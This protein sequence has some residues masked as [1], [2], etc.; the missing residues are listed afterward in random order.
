MFARGNTVDSDVDRFLPLILP[1]EL[2]DGTTNNIQTYI[3]DAF[4]DGYFGADEGSVFDGTLIRLR[5]VSLA[6]V[7]PERLLAKTPF[8]RIGITLSGE[9]LWYDAVNFPNGVNF[10]PEVLS[11]GVGNGR[12]FDYFTGP[13]AKKYGVTINA[14]F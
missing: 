13:T 14:T 9:N 10:D 12:G 6:Y 8:G 1:G 4:F 2:A 5:Q 11:L 3:G 7:L